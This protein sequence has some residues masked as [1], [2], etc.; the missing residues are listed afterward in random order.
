MSILQSIVLGIIQGISEFL[1]I[2]SSGHLVLIPFFFGW[3]YTPLY[4]TVIVHFATLLA[5]MSVFYRDI[6]KIVKAVVMAIF[7]REKRNSSDFKLGIFI[8]I[9]T[10]P[11][12][13]A[14]FFLESFVESLFSKPLLVA[15]FLLW[16]AVLLWIGEVIGRKNESASEGRASRAHSGKD[17]KTGLSYLVAFIV[18]AG[19]ALAIFPGISRAGSTISFARIFGIKRAQAVRFSFLLAVP[20]ILGSFLFELYN[21]YDIIFLAG[22]GNAWN[23]IAGFIFAY[24]AG[25]GAI[26]FLIRLVKKRNL[27]AF[28]VY[29]ICLSVIAFIFYIIEK[30]I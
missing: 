15:I 2:S 10:I 24:L 5:V 27:N 18:G 3:D 16:T 30:N 6:Y 1:P 14:G 13:V 20:V 29:C 28:A 19:Q 23:L 9:G 17:S 21:S 4:F 8:I 25:F 22:S 11:A 26:R 12:A 7:I